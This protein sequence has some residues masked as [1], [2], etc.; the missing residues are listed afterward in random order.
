VRGEPL[1]ESLPVR[2]G[3]NVRDT[4]L[5]ALFF[6]TATVVF[7]WPIAPRAATGLADLWD[8]KLNAWI[9]HWDYH[10]FFR[11]PLHL[12]DANIF[13]PSR[14]AL[15]FSENLF[16]AALFG[17]PLYA[18]GISTL[19]VYNV[20]FLLGMFLSALAAW[21][22]A[23]DVTGDSV[24]SAVAGL[25][26]AFSP[27]RIAQIPHIQ[28]QWGTFLALAL[29]FLLRYLDGGQRRDVVLFAVCFAWNALCNIHYAIFS[30][31]LFAVVLVYE[32]LVAGWVA[33]RRRLL[34][35]LAAIAVAGIVV[36]P[37]FLPYAHASRLYGMQRS[38]GEIDF[39]SGAWTSFLSSGGQNK[40]YGAVTSRWDKAE[41]ELFPGI[42][43]LGLAAAAL[44]SRRRVVRKPESRQAPPARHQLIRALDLCIAAAM[45]VL[46]VALLWRS[47]TGPLQLHDRGRILVILT[48]FVIFRLAIAF[49][50][51]SR[52]ENLGDLL[53][54]FRPGS[55]PGLFAAVAL[56]GVVVALGTHTPYY[57]FGVQS[58]GPLLRIIRVPA[59]GVV[60]FD[61]G[62][63]V[64]AA[65]GL[66]E[67]RRQRRR[68]ARVGIA[69]AALLAIGF[70]YRAFPLNVHPVDPRPASVRRWLAD[71]SFA[72][73][74][75]EWPL[76][77]E[78]DQEYEFRSTEHWKPLVN[79]S[80]GFSPPGYE[81]L[82]HAFD[83][84]P[85]PDLIWKMLAE[86]RVTL[87]VLHKELLEG[88]LAAAYIDTVRRG[89]R[90][91]RLVDARSFH[92]GDY[93]DVVFRL[94]TGSPVLGTAVADAAATNQE[95]ESLDLLA[96]PPFGYI[97]APVEGETI[98]AGA[99]A[100]GWA[101]DDSGV[102]WVTVSI[103]DG[104]PQLATFGHPHPG[105]P[106]LY[107]GYPDSTRA[108]FGVSIPLLSSGAHTLS[109][110]ILAK[111]GG[112]ARMRRSFL[113]R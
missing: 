111:D 29:L 104:Q 9:L 3:R 79:G 27:W 54:Q 23:R 61:L 51:W 47:R 106:R 87:L 81:E 66:S 71:V 6:L 48:G 99:W 64:L 18:A 43:A 21:A 45:L 2:P 97:D 52:F 55:R 35:A 86:R 20:V 49:P 36:L 75:I 56:L 88:D 113:L 16:G 1:A 42:V 53:R 84:K 58:L 68:F 103:D 110:T 101:L 39:Y 41:G 73:G 70:E 14:Y 74:V 112:Q 28:Y 8:A 63:A 30:G 96:H 4:A 38:L 67:I 109:V 100:Y 34:G 108:G 59:R 32:G 24:A 44:T 90:Q 107:P 17:F 98:A 76:G 60:L 26:Y 82:V 77:A 12:F 92:H 91:G 78:Y 37:V 95:L 22:L 13:Y 93:R 7:T 25:V 102:A 57:R 40:L 10:Q 80:S 62:L 11:D 94:S 5:A 31:F 19:A 50:R 89:I 69:A 65:L 46:V 72:G 33:S 15:A 105:P 83:Q 85:V